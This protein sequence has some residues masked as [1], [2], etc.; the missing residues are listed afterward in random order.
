MSG[1]H[2]KFEDIFT[3]YY[4][5]IRRFLSLKVD[6]QTAEDLTQLTFMKA[7][8]HINSFRGDSS[9]FTWICHIA[10]NNLKNEFR[11]K[12]RNCET[13]V[14][15][16]HL[17]NRFIS[18]EFTKNVEIR[19][20]ITLA[21]EQLSEID[22]EIISLHYDVGCTLKEVSEITQ[23]KLSAVKNRLYRAL[24][25]LRKELHNDEEVRS[26]MSVIDYITVISKN[27]LKG[28]SEQDSKVY[29]DIINHLK[30]SVDRICTQLRH[31]PSKKISI[32]IYPDLQSFHHAVGEPDAPNWFM[33]I[34]ENNT[35][36]IASPLH[37]GP[38]HTYQSILKSTLHLYT[39]W[40]VT[41]INPAAPKW[42]YQGL[43]GYEAGL[44]TKEY[45]DS[46]IAELVKHS[47]IPTF[48]DLEDNTWEFDEKKGF[49]F[50]YTLSEFVLQHYGIEAL[51][52]IIRNPLDFE[53]AFNCSAA[54]IHKLWSHTLKAR[55]N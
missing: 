54:E 15:L 35:I 16:N 41:D 23:M 25:K 45:I 48:E 34:I 1:A 22:R 21:L 26:F 53:D 36:K 51:N 49:Q 27:E 14:D 2:D 19:I 7:M 38:E 55:L 6:I 47:Q 8:E 29:Q 39:I 9:L 12:D 30:T 50:S 13:Y 31:Q 32:E 18:F 17:E 5:R 52:K 24:E 10:N 3:L 42:L 28:A 4:D 44:M 46:S 33:G 37:P 43:G 11:R 40:L 20:D